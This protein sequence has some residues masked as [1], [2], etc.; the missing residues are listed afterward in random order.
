MWGWVSLAVMRISLEEPIGSHDRSNFRLEDFDC[1][2]AVVLEIG[3]EIN[4]SHAAGPQLALEP[5]P[6]RQSG[7]EP[8]QLPGAGLS[9]GGTVLQCNDPA[10]SDQRRHQ[11][12]E[13]QRRDYGLVA[14]F[15]GSSF[16]FT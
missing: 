11:C 14:C 16:G 1:D 4:G 2:E 5:V 13:D 15:V 10:P 7:F 6:V 8:L 9:S 12:R 3:G